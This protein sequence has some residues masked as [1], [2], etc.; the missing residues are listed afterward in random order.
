MWN[1]ATIVLIYNL[2]L[3]NT[4]TRYK[5][6][7][8]IKGS[9]ILGLP[10]ILRIVFAIIHIYPLLI[11]SYNNVLYYKLTRPY[12]QILATYLGSC[13][14]ANYIGNSR[15]TL[16]LDST[17]TPTGGRPWTPYNPFSSATSS[18]L[19]DNFTHRGGPPASVYQLQW[20]A[21]WYNTQI[22]TVDWP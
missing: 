22:E 1:N 20:R 18:C 4:G 7:G 10:I 15:S 17:K 11:I 21:V 19:S 13:N 6:F 8:F 5:S 3:G 9:Y 12:S 2:Y 14:I 16:L